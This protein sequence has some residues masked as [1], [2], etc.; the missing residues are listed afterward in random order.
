MNGNS[1]FKIVY[2]GTL[3]RMLGIDL[4]IEAVARLLEQ[5]PEIQF[6]A[7][8]VGRNIEEFIYLSRKLGIEDHVHFS[9]KTY[10]VEIL[11]S[12]LGEMDAGIIP[13]RRNAA[14]ELMLPVKLLEYVSM[15]IPVVSA[16]LKGIEHY[17]S[18]DMVCFFESENVEAMSAAILSI[19][20]DKD[21]RKSQV[22]KA[23]EFLRKYGWEKHQSE[24]IRTYQGL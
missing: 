1:K 16:K 19:Y 15:G 14:T 17:L 2:H 7:I 3:D 4:V 22:F 21:K 10:P 24:L 11:P 13:N 8:G 6:H 5:I 23:Q 20:R 18:E 9:R 12:I